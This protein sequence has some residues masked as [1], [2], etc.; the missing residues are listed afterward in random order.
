MTNGGQMTYV[1]HTV[2]SLRRDPIP[3]ETVGLVL[4]LGEDSSASE[5]GQRVESLGGEVHRELEFDRLLVEVE[6]TELDEIC[7]MA[8][9]TTIETD[10]VLDYS[11]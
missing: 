10:A 1:S 9:V 3:D 6:Q 11:E 8:G 7:E 4:T 2:R 5:I